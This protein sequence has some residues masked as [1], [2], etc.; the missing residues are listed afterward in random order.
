[1]TKRVIAVVTAVMMMLKTAQTRNNDKEELY[2]Y[3]L[4]NL[5]LDDSDDE[6]TEHHA[7]ADGS[8]AQLIKI[9]QETRKYVWMAKEKAYLPVQL[10]CAA[11]LEI[12][13]S[14]PLESEV[15]LMTLLP[16]L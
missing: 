11:L 13:L 4:E 14:S 12:Y 7:G 6:L 15:I 5:L 3:I 16:M 8:L 2:P 1:M 10:R 9:K